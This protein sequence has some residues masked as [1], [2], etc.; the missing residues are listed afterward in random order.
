MSNPLVDLGKFGQSPWIDSISRE[1][2][3]SGALKKMIE[4]DGLKGLTSNPSIFEKALAAGADYDNLLARA[5]GQGIQDPKSLFEALAVEDI[6]D[7]ADLLLPV[8][9]HSGGTDGFVSL[10]VSPK[11]AFDAKRTVEEALRLHK[12]V[13]RK[14]LMIKIP[15]TRECLPAISETLAAGISVNVTLIF[16]IERYEEVMEAYLLGLERLEKNGG[17]LSSVHSVASFFVSRLD[18]AVE[19]LVAEDSPLI[20]KVAIANA[21]IAYQNFLGFFSSA[22]FAKLKERGA[23]VQRPLWAS[24]SA[25]NAAFSDVLYVDQLIGKDTV[26]TIPPATWKAFRDHGTV[27]NSIEN[28]LSEARQTMAMLREAGINLVEVTDKLEAEG[29]D[30]FVHSFDGLLAGVSEK[31]NRLR[32][33]EPVLSEKKTADGLDPLKTVERI[34]KKDASLWKSEAAHR[35]IIDQSLGW[36]IMPRTMPARTAEIRKFADEIR[37]APFEHVVVLGMGGSSLAPEVL[38]RSL[39]PVPGFPT[40]HILDSTEPESVRAVEQAAPPEKT[41]YIV[42][43]KS[44]TTVEPARFMDYF[45]GKVKKYKGDEAGEH[46]VAITD[47]GRPMLEK[48]K[49]LKFRKIFLNFEDI[50]GRYSALSYFGI[51]PAVLSGLDADRLLERAHKMADACALKT[52]DNPGFSLGIKLGELAGSG[53]DK[54]HFLL[55][56]GVDALGLWLEQLI[57]ESLGKEG[58]GVVPV[59]GTGHDSAD[60]HASDK[61]FIHFT[62][63]SIPDKRLDATAESL[64]SAGHPVLEIALTDEY[65][66]AGEFFRWEFATA[67]LGACMKINPFD[68]PNV[69]EAKEKTVSLLNGL[70]KTGQLPALEPHVKEDGL[71]IAFSGA[72]LN[73]I[74]KTAGLSVDPAVIRFLADVEPGDYVGLLAYIG[75][76]GRYDSGLN[77]VRE[78][79]SKAT[80]FSVQSGYGPRYLHSTG[81]LHKGGRNNGIFL[82]L[83]REDGED[84]GI[85]GSDY[86]FG[87]LVRAQALGDFQALEAAGRRAA[88]IGISGSVDAALKRISKTLEAAAHSAMKV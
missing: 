88:M 23:P 35:A 29:V 31:A 60:R 43:S 41:L 3:T 70:K 7:A 22:R 73:A 32:G 30:A 19:K 84:L 79:A 75:S 62:V 2:I 83:Y 5:L 33:Q 69:Q 6:R 21:K 36:L 53:R 14:N 65:D 54:I 48:A 18:S 42:A 44:G 13:G 37:K 34:W 59:T 78:A 45:L 55:P 47:P 58:K 26:N 80:G 82:I 16:S 38:R 77:K 25:K 24:T 85:D 39:P 1:M 9:L 15:A 12:A 4:E 51:V 61:V 40:L 76:H 86:T 52:P 8:H 56:R 67:V 74:G 87:Q 71:T 64:R 46:F 10:E 27:S 81:Q 63:A 17:D 49:S 57:A 20:G 50:G 11:L 72:S 66:I 28:G 68:Q